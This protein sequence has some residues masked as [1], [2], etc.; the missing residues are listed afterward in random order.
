MS[1]AE[2]QASRL[3]LSAKAAVD[4]DLDGRAD[5]IQET[6]F[7]AYVPTVTGSRVAIDLAEFAI[8]AGDDLTMS[9]N[10]TIAR[11][12]NAPLR[13]LGRRILPRPSSS[14]TTSGAT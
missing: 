7:E 9:D 8:F 4:L 13:Q 14:S 12:P 2:I 6:T 3:Q 11:W 5:G 1:S 10:A